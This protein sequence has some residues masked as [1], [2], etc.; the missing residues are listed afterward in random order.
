MSLLNIDMDTFRSTARV[1]QQLPSSQHEEYFNRFPSYW[2]A[3]QEATNLRGSRR[4][5]SFV[6]GAAAV[7]RALEGCA[8]CCR[9]PWRSGATTMFT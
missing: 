7:P 3:L 8:R 9:L 1:D 6:K 4:P 5:P 2:R